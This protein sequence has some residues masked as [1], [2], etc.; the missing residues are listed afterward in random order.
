MDKELKN[1]ID[2][3]NQK[4]GKQTGYSTPKNYFEGIEED[5]FSSIKAENFNKKNSFKVPNNYFNKVEEDI[6][7]K[8]NNQDTKETTV[9]SLRKRV[10][11]FVPFAAAA[12]ILLFIGLN[13]FNTSTGTN[14]TIDDITDADLTA[15]YE[16]G[17]GDTDDDE[18]ALALNITDL[19][20]DTFNDVSNDHLEEYLDGIDSSTYLNEIQ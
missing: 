11:Q 14:Y 17:Y 16:N 20:S 3:I 2:F 15:W 6:F 7:A 13:Y 5:I 10:L 9:I 12:S 1:N 18:L 19:E 4:V 8:I